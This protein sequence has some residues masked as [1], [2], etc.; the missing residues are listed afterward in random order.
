MDIAFVVDS[1]ASIWAEN[2][3][4]GLNFIEDFVNLFDISP[5]AVRVSL[6]TYGEIVYEEDAF[7]FDTYSNNHDLMAA[8]ARIPYRAGIMTNTGGG[9][10]YMLNKQISEAR[11]GVRRVAIVLTDGN[12]QETQK[13]KNAALEA[14]ETGLEVFAI[15]V[16]HDVSTQELHN[17]ASD[18]RHVIEVASYHLLEGIKKRLAYEACDQQPHP[19]CEMDPVDLSFV[20]DSSTS[21]GQGNFTV[22]MAFVK[23]F[24]NAFLINPTAVRVSAVTYGE[25]VY[26]QDAFDFDTFRDK[27]Q[28]LDTLEG[29]TWRHGLATNT[30]A[31][32]Q[33]MREVQM[34]KA[35]PT[36]A[37]ICIVITDGQS[38]EMQKT[39]DQAKL[40]QDAG[41]V[42]YAVGVGKIGEQL[43]GQ[44]LLNIAGDSDR[45]VTAKN[46]AELN[47]IKE[48]LTNLAC[49][50]IIKALGIKAAA[51]RT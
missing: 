48:K 10:L 24:V 1:S 38:Q 14:L 36:S 41:I 13:T 4:L 23:D 22:G 15:G 6:V 39:A 45:V 51:Y 11:P 40:A 44:E 5:S 3:T 27:K 17:I 12:S 31:G 26:Q 19:A 20:I 29:I 49:S 34:P 2:F 8:I 32:I 7:G 33:Y 50:G 9:I 43:D 16:G 28:V 46:Y 18:D 42:M 37:H 25:I 35:R 21:I 30:G 47:L